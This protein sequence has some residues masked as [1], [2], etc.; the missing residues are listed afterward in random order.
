MDIQQYMLI[1]HLHVHA[2][3]DMLVLQVDQSYV[4]DCEH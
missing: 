2:V 1:V 4:I 3:G